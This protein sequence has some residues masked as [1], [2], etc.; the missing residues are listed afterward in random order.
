MAPASGQGLWGINY[1]KLYANHVSMISQNQSISYSSFFKEY[2][3]D[4][5]KPLLY[6]VV[7]Y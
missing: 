2:T 7:I 1:K 3:F 5:I 6:I 4:F